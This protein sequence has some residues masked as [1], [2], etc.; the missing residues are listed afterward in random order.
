MANYAMNRH[1]LGD[2][3]GNPNSMSNSYDNFIFPYEDPAIIN[4]DELA[5]FPKTTCPSHNG[6]YPHHE[7]H[8]VNRR[9]PVRDGKNITI[10]DNHPE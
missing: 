1:D 4:P 7:S 5:S 6:G 2:L 8:L 10:T 9:T 3:G